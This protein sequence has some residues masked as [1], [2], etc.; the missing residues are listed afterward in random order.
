MTKP[1]PLPCGCRP[2]RLCPEARRLLHEASAAYHAWL[3]KGHS[4]QLWEA[5][6]T[7]V[8]HMEMQEE[9]ACAQLTSR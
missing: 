3:T 6:R 8:D 9:E 4:P 5:W 7:T 1:A 2:G